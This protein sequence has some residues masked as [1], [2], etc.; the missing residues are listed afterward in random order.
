MIC[1]NCG[2]E[3]TGEYGSGRFCSSKCA[4]GFSTKSKRQ[5]INQKVSQTLAGREPSNK[6]K[7]CPFHPTD[8]TEARAEKF[9]EQKRLERQNNINDFLAGKNEKKHARVIRSYL[10]ETREYKCEE[11]ENKEWNGQPIPLQVEH[12]DGN[13]ENNVP[14]NLK[15]LCPNCHALTPTWG[16]RNK[17]NGRHYRRV[18][19]AEGKS[20]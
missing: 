12:I 19:Y 2:I 17:G 16:N 1:E 8:K 9:R 10:L 3:H 11:C 13:W 5:E 7:K 4:R 14:E 18:R 20:Y 15:L 6:G